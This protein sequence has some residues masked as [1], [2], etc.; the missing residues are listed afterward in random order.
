MAKMTEKELVVHL[1]DRTEGSFK[2]LVD[3]FSDKIYLLAMRYTKSPDDAEELMQEVLLI[4]YRKIH[5][6]QGKSSLSTWI[7][8]ITSNTALTFLKKKN[9]KS[10]TAIEDTGLNDDRLSQFISF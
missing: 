5:T 9:A 3:R 8:S 2:M 10:A 7:Y 1:I 4:I 6:F